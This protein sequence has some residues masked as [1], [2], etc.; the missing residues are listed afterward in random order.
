MLWDYQKAE[1]IPRF[2]RAAL[3]EYGDFKK[4]LSDFRTTFHLEDCS[5]RN[6]DKFLWLP[7]E[8]AG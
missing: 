2:H 7:S 5:L 3:R 1:M 8:D 6:V 4:I